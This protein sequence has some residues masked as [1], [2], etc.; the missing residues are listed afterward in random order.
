MNGSNLDSIRQTK[1]LKIIHINTRSVFYKLDELK[2]NLADFDIIV[3]SETWLNESIDD[4]M[5]HWEN[6]QLVRLDREGWRNKKGGGLCIYVRSSIDED[7]NRVRENM[8][9]NDYVNE[10]FANIGSKLARECTPGV[11]NNGNDVA[12]VRRD[13]DVVDF[14]RTPF[15]V[16]EV[17]KVCNDINICKSASIPDVKSM[18]LKHTFLDNIDMVTK[19]FNS[20]L[21]QSI[22]PSS[23]KLSTIVPLPKIPHPSTASDLRPVALTP[24]PG[25]LM[26]KLI[27]NRLQRWISNN[28]LLSD[29]QH[30]FRKEKSTV[31]AIAAFLNEIYC[32]V[33]T[34]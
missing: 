24:L 1:G 3:L 13:I 12:G 20:S 4:S 34:H 19:I 26:E 33:Q 25:K 18:V 21:M 30:G 8:D 27:C 31:S 2:Y 32:R 10:Y 22:F 14:V 11:I 23:W 17:F 6:F 9:L 16:E 15:T 7:T 29:A 28:D 5:L